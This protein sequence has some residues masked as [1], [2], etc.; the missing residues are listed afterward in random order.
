MEKVAFERVLGPTVGLAIQKVRLL[1][2]IPS[3]VRLLWSDLTLHA[4]AR[5]EQREV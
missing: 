1:L 5:E 4:A 2:H 3:T